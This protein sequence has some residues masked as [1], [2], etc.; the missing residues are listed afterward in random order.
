VAEPWLCL[1]AV[2]IDQVC[3]LPITAYT[4]FP[5]PP[6]LAQMSFGSSHFH[7]VLPFPRCVCCSLAMSSTYGSGSI[8][9]QLFC[10]DVWDW[11]DSVTMPSNLV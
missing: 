7:T 9:L 8:F 5:L 1:S 3:L 2:P 4:Q 10:P 6:Q 11:L